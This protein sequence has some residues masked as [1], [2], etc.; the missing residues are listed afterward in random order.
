MFGV[1]EV[2]VT[3]RFEVALPPLIRNLLVIGVSGPIRFAIGGNV[4][5][6]A[7]PVAAVIWKLWSTLTA[8][9]KL[10]SPACEARKMQVPGER[11]LTPIGFGGMT[12]GDGSMKI[13][14]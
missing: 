12:I 10:V 6:C 2:I 4:M 1:S 14:P 7:M 3:S 9:V 13:G 8:A 11:R 5:V